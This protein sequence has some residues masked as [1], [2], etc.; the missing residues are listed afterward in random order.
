MDGTRALVRRIRRLGLASTTALLL[1]AVL[2]TDVL[3]LTWLSDTP[4]SPTSFP[5]C[6]RT[7]KQR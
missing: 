1:C 7:R 3:G 4:A 6:Y 5:L 2:T